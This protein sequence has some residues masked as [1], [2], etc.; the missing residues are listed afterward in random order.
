MSEASLLGFRYLP[1]SF[2]YPGSLCTYDCKG[3]GGGDLAW[4]A[5]GARFLPLYGLPLGDE[6]SPTPA[7]SLTLSIEGGQSSGM[8]ELWGEETR[9]KMCLLQQKVSSRFCRLERVVWR[10]T[11][12]PASTD[13]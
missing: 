3:G 1:P 11:P 7:H 8:D 13:N 9:R 4:C 12:P 2:L 10:A 5:I 6:K